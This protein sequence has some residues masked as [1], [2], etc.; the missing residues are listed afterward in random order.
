MLRETAISVRVPRELKQKI[1][2]RA[3]RERR[4][5]SAQVV[6]ELERAVADEAPRA[7]ARPALGMFPHG[8]VPSEQDFQEARARL[9]ARLGRRD[10]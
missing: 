10:G 3:K 2:A 5:L 8:Q 6:V 7:R 1:E 9:W 4:S